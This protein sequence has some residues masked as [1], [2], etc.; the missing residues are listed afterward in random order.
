MSYSY[1]LLIEAS[2]PSDPI[3][4]GYGFSRHIAFAMHLDFRYV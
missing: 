4:I 1:F 3:I 2:T